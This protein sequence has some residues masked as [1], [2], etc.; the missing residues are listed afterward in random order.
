MGTAIQ[1][2]NHMGMIIGNFGDGYLT[3]VYYAWLLLG[4]LE[5]QHH[6]STA[7]TGIF[8]AIPPVFGI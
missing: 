6:M 4:F 5:I 3:W 2:P 7:R 1:M 8:V